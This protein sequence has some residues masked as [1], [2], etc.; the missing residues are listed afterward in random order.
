VTGIVVVVEPKKLT[1][2]VRPDEVVVVTERQ[3][4]GW[5]SRCSRTFGPEEM[6][7]IAS[8]AVFARTWHPRPAEPC[9]VEALRQ[10]FHTLQLLVNQARRRRAA[11]VLGVPAVGFLILANIGQWAPVLLHVLTGR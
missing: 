7:R 8:A 9:N 10:N 3:L 4:L 5:L 11:W 6:T 2:K 1:I